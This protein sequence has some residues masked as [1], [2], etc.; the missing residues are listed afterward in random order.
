MVTVQA[1]H[2]ALL[3]STTRCSPFAHEVAC[4][5]AMARAPG[6][7]LSETSSP[8]G[9]EDDWRVQEALALVTEIHVLKWLI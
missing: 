4:G 2:A 3:P 9:R 1:V 7:L 6:R 5:L 8:G